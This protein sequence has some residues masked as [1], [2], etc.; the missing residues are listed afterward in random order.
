MLMNRFRL[1]LRRLRRQLTSVDRNI[2]TIIII[3][4]VFILISTT[5]QIL[6]QQYRHF[7]AD[8]IT[9]DINSK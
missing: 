3:I 8:F 1:I 7:N 9:R 6:L 4:A 5:L 2:Q